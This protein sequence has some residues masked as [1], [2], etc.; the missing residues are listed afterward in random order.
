MRS[1]VKGWK[2]VLLLAA[3]ALW[4]CGMTAMAEGA[5]NDNS[6]SSLGITT[7]GVTVSPEFYYST[8]EYNVTV[9]AG[10]ARLELDPVP[11]NENAWIVDISGQDLSDGKTTVEIV[12]SAES[13]AQYTYYLYVEE[14]A[15]AD[16]GAA[17]TVA[18]T[19]P[20]TET[21]AETEP[22]TEDPRYVKVDR[23]SLEE[24]ENT[25]STLKTETSSYRDRVNLLMKILYGLIAFCVVLLFIV[26]NLILKRR[27]LKAELQAY[28]G[29]G[30]PQEEPEGENGYGAGAGYGG[31]NAPDYDGTT[32]EETAD[33][34]G[35]GYN[36]A[37]NYSGAGYDEAA[38]Y[39]DAGYGEAA[40][41]GG[42]Y[43]QEEKQAPAG[44]KAREKKEPAKKE[45]LQ[46]DP[47]TV[48][49]PSKAKKKA[50]KM[51]E[52][53]P[54]QPEYDYQ[55]DPQAAKGDKNN[56]EVTMIDL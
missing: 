29:Y 33:Y 44:R 26:I 1:K 7:E 40:G 31:Y 49:K 56:V 14:E 23:N 8:I 47:A 27:D 5:S 16:A 43:G 9:P 48:P 35:A 20:E 34:G 39:G 25:I 55:P 22:E 3:M 11:S 50:K 30:Y 24:A 17:G 18:E 38:D 10:T 2:R 36:E 41:R 52:Y 15:G 32:Y 45:E 28:R 37:V 12:V 19:E 51:P 53:Q 54:P 46:D 42:A 21:E 4:L 6:L 13:G